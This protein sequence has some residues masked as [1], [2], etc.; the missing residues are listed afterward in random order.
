MTAEEIFIRTD[1]TKYKMIVEF[2]LLGFNEPYYRVTIYECL[3]KKRTWKNPVDT[4]SYAYRY[5]KMEDRKTDVL[6]QQL[7]F[8]SQEEIETVKNK[9]WLLLK[10]QQ[11]SLTACEKEALKK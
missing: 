9:C 4:E 8:V 10:P 6:R 3:P 7:N 5:L 1:G 11:T 2:L